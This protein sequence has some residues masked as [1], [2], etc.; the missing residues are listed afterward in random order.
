M[1]PKLSVVIIAKNEESK[2]EAC[3]ESVKWADEII[4]VDSGS[5]DRTREICLRYTDRFFVESW[6]GYG[7]QKNKGIARTACDWVLNIDADE[8]VTPELGEEIR[9]LISSSTETEGFQIPFRHFIGVK[10][11]A[12]GGYTPDYHL[13][14]FRSSFRFEGTVHETVKCSKVGHLK[15][16][17]HHYTYDNI[18]GFVAKINRYTSLEADRETRPAG[19]LRFLAHPA[20]EFAKRYV[21]QKGFLDGRLGLLIC[22]MHAAYV[23]LKLAKTME[24]QGWK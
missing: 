4:V 5:T 10:L 6:E 7:A 3:L 15:N 20:K 24:K 12:H 17:I 9:R 2:I 23:L 22:G 16:P 18:A 21:Y 14:L 1:A 8:R 11:I 19:I 13:R